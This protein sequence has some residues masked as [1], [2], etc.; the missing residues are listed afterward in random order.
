MDIEEVSDRF[1]AHCFINGL[2]AYDG[3]I[4]LGVEENMISNK[5]AVKLCLEHE[6]IINPEEDDVEPGVILG[7]SFLCMTKAIIDFEART[8]H[9]LNFNLDDVRLLG[10]EEL[11]PFVCKM[12]KSSRNK[13]R[14]MENLNFFYQNIGTSSSAGEEERPIIETMAY[15]DKYKKILDEI[16]KDEVKLDGKIIKEEKEALG[17]E[18]M[19]KVDRGLTMINHTQAEAMGILKNVLCQVGFTTLIAKFLI[20]DIPIDYDSPIVVGRGFLRMIGGIVNTPER[21]FLTFDEFCH[22]T[23]RAARSD[24][25]RNAKSDSDDEEEYHIKKNKFGALIYGPKSASYL[26]CNDPAERSGLNFSPQHST[27]NETKGESDFN[28]AL[29]IDDSTSSSSSVD[30]AMWEFKECIDKIDRILGNMQFCDVF[31]RTHAIFKP[32]RSSDHAPDVFVIPTVTKCPP[33]PFKFSNIVT[34]H[35]RFNEVVREG[36]SYD[37]SRFWMF[38]LVKKL[39]QLKR[40]LRILL[41]DHGNID[42]NVIRLRTELDRVQADLDSDPFNIELR[43]E[44]VAMSRSRIDVVMDVAGTIFANDRVADAFVSHYEVFLGQEGTTSCLNT[45]DLFEQGPDG[46][47]AVFFKEAWDIVGHDVIQAV[48][49]FFTNGKLLKELNHTIIALILKA[50]D[51][52]DWNFLRAD[53]TG[54][55]FH[56]KMILWIMECVTT[57]S[58]SISINGSLHGHFKGKW[59]LRQGDPISPYLFTI[60]M[61]VLTLILK[62]RVKEADGFKYHWFCSEMELNNLCFVDD[63]FLFAHGD[64]ISAKI[65]MESLDEFKHVSGL[66]PSLPKSTTYFCNVLNHTKLAILQVMPFEEGRLPVKYLGVPLVSS[67]LVYKDC[68]ELIVKVHARSMKKGKSNVAWEVVCL[69]KDEG[70]LVIRRLD[71]FNKALMATHIWKLLSKKESLWVTWIHMRKIKDRNFWD[72]P[73]RGKMSWAWRKVLQLHPIIRK[74]VWHKIGDRN[75][76]SIWFDQWCHLSPLADFISHRDMY[77]ACLSSSSKVADLFATGSFVW[78]PDLVSK[79]PTVLDISS[80]RI[81]VDILDKLEWKSWDGMINPFSVSYVWHS[82]RPCDVKVDWVDVAGLASHAE[83]GG[84]ISYAAVLGDD[85]VVYYSYGQEAN[86]EVIEC[87]MSSIR[88]KLM[89]CRFKK[90]KVGGDVLNRWNLPESLCS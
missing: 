27:L 3:E 10:E 33:K 70:G 56:D 16:W 26:N 61:E 24:A 31:V 54:F 38:R 19:K 18:E 11:P 28:A 4:N 82:I 72:L 20:L 36:W 15:H 79:Y 47:T 74:F 85:F 89:S 80:P 59:G 64:V 6:F 42:D 37:I 35:R 63:L 29:F 17:R 22:H 40:P 44:E 34:H 83:L 84:V 77:R 65:I 68:K 67:R 71:M 8:D 55:G 2:E 58:F 86:V 46:Y 76:T 78:P 25:M 81:S 66:T 13:K 5:Y 48:K 49:E 7:R 21:L 88:L 14:A 50:Y 1:V 60:V 62:R 39:K 87:I 57:T 30:I 32:Y 43:E 51:T 52:V 73:C 9:L 41:Y 90:S 75:H 45:N 23:F 69:P 12:G 53:L